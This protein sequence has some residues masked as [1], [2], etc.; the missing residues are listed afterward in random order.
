MK[1]RSRD[2]AGAA[3]SVPIEPDP[4][5]G[6]RVKPAGESDGGS[7]SGFSSLAAWPG[8]AR[9]AVSVAL[10]FH[11]AA[12]IAGALGVPPSSMLER[13]IADLF[14]PYFDLVDLGYSYRY[15]TEPPP[16]PV[17]TAMLGFGD[18]RPEETLRLPGRTVPGPRMRHQRQLAL[19]NSLFMDVQEARQRTGDVKESRLARA[20]ARHICA[21]RPDCRTVTLHIQQHLIPDLD[22]VREAIARPGAPP[23]DLWAESLL[24]TPEWIGDY[25]CDGF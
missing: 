10:A 21:A 6:A 3:S 5:A 17:V 22:Q 2:R 12:V 16:T 24:T 1:K 4:Q 8:A 20:Y 19:A 23:F 11:L 18:G 15:Y 14:K 25:A 7:Q 9:S 13:S